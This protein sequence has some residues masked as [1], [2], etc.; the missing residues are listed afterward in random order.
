MDKEIKDPETIKNIINSLFGR[1]PV[2]MLVNGKPIPI[3]VV[4]LS[5][6]GLVIK[7][8]GEKIDSDQR[9][10]TLTNNGNLLICLFKYLGGDHTGLQILHPLSISVRP[11]TRSSQRISINTSKDDFKI[12]VTN[13]ISQNDIYG[14]LHDDSAKVNEIKQNNL[15][16]LKKYKFNQINLYITERLDNRMRLMHNYDKP[17]FIPDKR[18]PESV[19]DE[20]LPYKEYFQLLKLS[21]NLDKVVAEI[22][23]PLKYKNIVNIGY[24]QIM[25]EEALEPKAFNAVNL[26]AAS[27]KR[28]LMS[29]GIFREEKDICELVDLSKNGISFYHLPTRS[30]NRTISLGGTIYF[31]LVLSE[32]KRILCRAIVRN[33]KPLEKHFRVGCQFFSQSEEEL[34]V[35][36]EILGPTEETNKQDDPKTKET[37]KKKETKKDKIEK[38]PKENKIIESEKS[39]DSEKEVKPV[40]EAGSVEEEKT[41]DSEEI[42]PEEETR[43]V[44]EEANS[45]ENETQ[46]EA[47][48]EGSDN[49]LEEENQNESSQNDDE[50]KT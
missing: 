25:N 34:A 10:L 39:V 49:N 50:T 41:E 3:K 13:I 44:S 16:K 27:I 1:L 6:Q 22:C 2:V 18:E 35:L 21:K 43:E 5:P 47:D 36:E 48:V 23:V 33:I 24:L 11:A 46:E 38:T 29:S 12:H 17:I 4:K 19:T 30:F 14:S 37:D 26:V 31:E 8:L 28:E 9:I 45:D 15:A 40:E 20:F 42:E 7:Y 32:E